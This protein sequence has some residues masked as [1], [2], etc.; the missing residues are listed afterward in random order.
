LRRPRSGISVTFRNSL[1]ALL[2]G[3]NYQVVV[4]GAL[5]AEQVDIQARGQMVPRR[6]RVF[7]LLRRY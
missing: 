6:I 2:Q 7:L 4:A 5:I 1:K 3:A